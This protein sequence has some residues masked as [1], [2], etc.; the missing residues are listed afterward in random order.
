MAYKNSAA[1]RDAYAA[2][3]KYIHYMENDCQR[4]PARVYI[5]SKQHAALCTHLTKIERERL[6]DAPAIEKFTDYRGCQVV[7]YEGK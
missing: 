4:N 2:M 6:H 5:T 3:D 1:A 7:I